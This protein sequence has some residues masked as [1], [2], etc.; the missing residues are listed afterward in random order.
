[1]TIACSLWYM[2]PAHIVSSYLCNVGATFAVHIKTRNLLL[3]LHLTFDIGHSSKVRK[4]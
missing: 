1:M 3:E 2:N 4:V